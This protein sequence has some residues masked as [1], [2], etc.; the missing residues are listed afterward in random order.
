MHK[1]NDADHH[2]E[3]HNAGHAVQ[4]IITADKVAV[5]DPP[6]PLL[7][8][9]LLYKS[10]EFEQA[11]PC[12]HRRVENKVSLC[13]FDHRGRL[14]VPAGLLHRRRAELERHGDAVDV[15]DLR[16]DGRRLGVDKDFLQEL[17]GNHRAFAQAVADERLGQIEVRGFKEALPSLSTK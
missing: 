4:V 17:E 12:G 14:V 6:V 8:P 9:L 15:E 16:K 11:S 7:E 1:R 5:M 3:V 2:K 10:F 13:T